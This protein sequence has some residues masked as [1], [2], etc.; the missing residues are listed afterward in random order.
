MGGSKLRCSDNYAIF[1]S[2]IFDEKGKKQR[3]FG[4]EI[5]EPFKNCTLSAFVPEKKVVVYETKKNTP[6]YGFVPNLISGFA[7]RL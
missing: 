3:F 1:V 6:I 2:L 5:V 7:P 4:V